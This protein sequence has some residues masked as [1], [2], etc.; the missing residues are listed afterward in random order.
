MGAAG[1]RERADRFALLDPARSQVDIFAAQINRLLEPVW[2][3][4]HAPRIDAR[5]VPH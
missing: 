2:R 5:F 4:A 3:C 1:E